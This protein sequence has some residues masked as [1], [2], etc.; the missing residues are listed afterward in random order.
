MDVVRLKFM[1]YVKDTIMK[2]NI[3]LIVCATIALVAC[4]KSEKEPTIAQQQEV[5]PGEK[6]TL[7][8]SVPNIEGVAGVPARKI[9]GEMASGTQSG[10]N[11]KWDQDDV[12]RVYALNGIDGDS[13]PEYSTFTMTGFDK[14]TGIAHFDGVV[15]TGGDGTNY[16][17]VYGDDAIQSKQK[18]TTNQIYKGLMRYRYMGPL[19]KN[20]TLDPVWSVMIVEMKSQLSWPSND[21]LGNYKNV[22]AEIYLNTLNI[23]QDLGNGKK[24]N[25]ECELLDRN[26]SA[27]SK[28]TYDLSYTTSQ[29][30]NF[31]IGIPVVVYPGKLDLTIEMAFSDKFVGEVYDGNGTKIKNLTPAIKKP[32]WEQDETLPINTK[33]TV[34]DTPKVDGGSGA[35]DL[36]IGKAVNVTVPELCITWLLNK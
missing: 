12:L 32:N 17:V 10:I 30:G 18:C 5:I 27:D 36:A 19:N 33:F 11:F 16:L 25:V 13:V 3:F 29:L 2:K 7:N 31:S 24:L 35:A 22:K 9:H 20:I 1:F 8:L 34:S 4:N 26:Y 6:I 21:E 15:P 14:G 23:T 28:L